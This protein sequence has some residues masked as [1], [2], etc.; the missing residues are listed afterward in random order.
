M[1]VLI[2]ALSGVLDIVLLMAVAVFTCA[3]MSF[4]WLSERADPT[5]RTSI[6]VLG[7]IPYLGAW[8]IIIAA[9]GHSAQN[10]PLF[11]HFIVGSLFVL[12]SFFGGVQ[13]YYAHGS[14]MKKERAFMVLSVV[15]KLTLAG[16]TYGG[17]RAL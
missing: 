9:Y 8:G 15:S 2:A 5:H 14:A 4:G 17:I 13:L 1:N 3:C 16:L 10:A 7:C 12:E 6:F 11:V